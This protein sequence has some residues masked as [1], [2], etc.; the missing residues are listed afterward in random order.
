ME[1]LTQPL[2]GE[3]GGTTGRKKEYNIKR[4]HNAV[5]ATAIMSFLAILAL[6]LLYLAIS[7]ISKGGG[8]LRLEW[9]VVG[10]SFVI[11]AVFI[12]SVFITLFFL[13]PM[14]GFFRRKQREN[15]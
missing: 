3:P 7:D 1:N 15:K 13:F 12:V 14:P 6:I 8:D 9:F 2:N 10:L 11:F 5:T 4:L